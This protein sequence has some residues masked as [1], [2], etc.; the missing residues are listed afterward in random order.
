MANILTNSN[1]QNQLTSQMHWLRSRCSIVESGSVIYVITEHERFPID[2]HVSILASV[3]LKCI[4][5][6]CFVRHRCNLK[7][8]SHKKTIH[9]QAASRRSYRINGKGKA[10]HTMWYFD[11]CF[12]FRRWFDQHLQAGNV[13]GAL[14]MSMGNSQSM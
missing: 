3:V 7:I 11:G 9:H 6:S 8:M 10:W 14:L 4:N 13:Y 12:Y 1:T 2:K 5:G